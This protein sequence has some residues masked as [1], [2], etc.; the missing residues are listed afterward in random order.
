MLLLA[1]AA[2]RPA[3]YCEGYNMTKQ[4]TSRI[5]E[6]A[7]YYVTTQDAHGFPELY[8]RGYGW[9]SFEPT[10]TDAVAVTDKKTATDMLSRAGIMILAA[11]LLVLLFSF[12]YPWLSHKIFI[13]RGRKRSPKDTV[14]AVM[15]RICKVYGIENV[16]TSQEVCGLVH[17]AAGADIT[18]TALLFDRA[19]YGEQMLDEHE[20]EKA[21]EEYIKAYDFYREAKKRRGITNR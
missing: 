11:A 8:I 10:V 15:H 6:R 3:R 20:K 17:E 21:L 19:V 16:N 4:G 9:V 14:K 1:R 7:N 13:I 2:G 12:V 5:N 18:E